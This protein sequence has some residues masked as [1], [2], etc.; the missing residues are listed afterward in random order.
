MAS[1]P[2][3]L[4]GETT[5]DP[6][7]RPG[8]EPKPPRVWKGVATLAIMAVLV[9]A[10]TGVGVLESDNL[11]SMPISSSAAA[12]VVGVVGATGPGPGATSF[13]PSTIAGS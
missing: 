2:K 3:Q 10:V 9:G 4:P 1:Y 13:S 5:G 6:R 8:G 11:R 12:P 7:R